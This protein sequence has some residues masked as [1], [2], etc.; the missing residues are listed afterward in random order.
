[1]APLETHADIPESFEGDLRNVLTKI[2]EPSDFWVGVILDFLNNENLEFEL[3]QD[4]HD[5]VWSIIARINQINNDTTSSNSTLRDIFNSIINDIAGIRSEIR[6]KIYNGII[7]T[8]IN[9][10]SPIVRQEVEPTVRIPT[11]PAE[12]ISSESGSIFD[13]PL[14]PWTGGVN[15]DIVIP[16]IRRTET[17]AESV[18]L[19][20]EADITTVLEMW[21]KLSMLSDYINSQYTWNTSYEIIASHAHGLAVELTVDNPELKLSIPSYYNRI[22]SE[23]IIL[24]WILSQ[25]NSNVDITELSLENSQDGESLSAYLDRL[26]SERSR[27]IASTA[28]I[29]ADA[30][31]DIHNTF[32]IL[33]QWMNPG[34]ASSFDSFIETALTNIDRVEGIS[35]NDVI[36][37]LWKWISLEDS[38]GWDLSTLLIW[39]EHFLQF[40][41]FNLSDEDFSDIIMNMLRDQE[42]FRDSMVARYWEGI[43]DESIV[44]LLLQDLALISPRIDAETWEEIFTSINETLRANF[45]ELQ[46]Q[47]WNGLSTFYIN[48]TL[49]WPI[50][51][52]SDPNARDKHI[53]QMLYF[54]EWLLQDPNGAESIVWPIW[55][56]VSIINR[57]RLL[58]IPL[59]IDQVEWDPW[60]EVAWLAVTIITLTAMVIW[61]RSKRMTIPFTN[62]DMPRRYI[63]LSIPRLRWEGRTEYLRSPGGF[64]E[65][66]RALMREERNSDGTIKEEVQTQLTALE[67]EFKKFDSSLTLEDLVKREDLIK[68]LID[69]HK[70]NNQWNI[71]DKIKRIGD[72][73]KFYSNRNV[74]YSTLFTEYQNITWNRGAINQISRR[75]WGVLLTWPLATIES[76][77]GSQQLNLFGI[78]RAVQLD[79]YVWNF[80]AYFDNLTATSYLNTIRWS[81]LITESTRDSIESAVEAERAKTTWW[82]SNENIAR[83]FEP[84]NESIKAIQ[85]KILATSWTIKDSYSDDFKW[86]LQTLLDNNIANNST[87]WLV[88][89]NL[90]TLKNWLQELVDEIPLIER[91]HAGINTANHQYLRDAIEPKVREFIWEQ[92]D[93]KIKDYADLVNPEDEA[94]KWIIIQ[95]HEKIFANP[96]TANQGLFENILKDIL[97][98]GNDMQAK[99]EFLKNTAIE[100]WLPRVFTEMSRIP[101]IDWSSFT[102]LYNFMYTERFDE[103]KINTVK[104]LFVRPYGSWFENNLIFS[105]TWR[106]NTTFLE[107]FIQH[108]NEVDNVWNGGKK[109]SEEEIRTEKTR[110]V[111]EF[112]N[113]VRN[114]IDPNPPVW[115][116]DPVDPIHPVDPEDEVT[117]KTWAELLSSDEHYGIMRDVMRD[118]FG[119]D[120]DDYVKDILDAEYDNLDTAYQDVTERLYNAWYL[121][122]DWTDDYKWANP[123]DIDTDNTRTDVDETNDDTRTDVD[124]EPERAPTTFER[125]TIA[126]HVGDLNNPRNE[127]ARSYRALLWELEMHPRWIEQWTINRIRADVFNNNY[128]TP[129]EASREINSILDTDYPGMSMQA[130]LSLDSYR[131]VEQRFSLDILDRAEILAELHGKRLSRSLTSQIRDS[132][133]HNRVS[134][135]EIERHLI[136]ILNSPDIGIQV[137]KIPTVTDLTARYIS[138]QTDGARITDDVRAEIERSYMDGVRQWPDARLSIWEIMRNAV[139]R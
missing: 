129:W 80:E 75:A 76:R 68:N 29:L 40:E 31:T 67:D 64:S 89:R 12:E 95:I 23:I 126:E 63:W 27:V 5:K 105:D 83:A 94:K 110:L 135:N 87:G 56:T 78:R 41:N 82:M 22:S 100:K 6:T 71:A 28:Q 30:K 81:S 32:P 92:G 50:I 127:F 124:N 116:I 113:E 36:V 112:K 3:S 84:I 8:P 128:R 53:V 66:Y 9:T 20:S 108:R 2:W 99:C 48:G 44:N 10:F 117:R 49:V 19:I 130:G 101:S 137:E 107:D 60:D 114:T 115:P 120:L 38:I 96:R 14:I 74:F 138:Q 21:T 93:N 34:D 62:I 13:T 86:Q 43:S 139:G 58:G 51:D 52:E 70:S 45:N 77:T 106:L 79:G 119:V 69:Y 1:M 25:L 57:L 37:N 73:I 55:T 39:S 15:E 123:E 121:V 103:G 16:E 26:K 125:R 61:A 24:Q 133:V 35:D 18:S 33:L 46:Q 47:L 104:Q 136:W 90:E 97:S 85:D 91:I 122:D 132:I 54:Y 88:S 4:S 59:A 7:D 98:N 42:W 111:T 11:A 17:A 65:R 118:R 109:M 134:W 72:E 131:I 102:D